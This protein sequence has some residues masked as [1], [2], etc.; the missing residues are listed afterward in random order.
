MA[1]L[2]YIIKPT[3]VMYDENIIKNFMEIHPDAKMATKLEDCEEVILQKGWTRSKK[4]VA[5][6]ELA[7]TLQKK[8]NE[9]YIYKD[10][11]K[12]HLN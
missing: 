1:Y 2:Y 12:V 5:E 4:A 6:K 8:C 10:F 9:G 7:A 11:Y 3:S